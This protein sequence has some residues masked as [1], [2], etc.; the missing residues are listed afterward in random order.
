MTRHPNLRAYLA[1]VFVPTLVLPFL[2]IVYVVARYVCNVPIPI[3]RIIIFPLAAVPNIWG[4]W[5]LLYMSAFSRRISLGLFGAILPLVLIPLGYV[6]T[7]LINFPVPHFIWSA[8]PVLIPVAMVLYYLVWKHII[9]FL[10]SEL[11][12]A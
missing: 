12:A 5:N 7:R 2:M 6:I 4:L 9:G 10:N 8:L 1:G 11:S 3:E